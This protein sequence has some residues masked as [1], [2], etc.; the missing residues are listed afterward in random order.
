[1]VVFC[2]QSLPAS[3]N[4]SLKSSY[5][6]SAAILQHGSRLLPMTGNF[7][8][9]SGT[10]PWKTYTPKQHGAAR[11]FNY[12]EAS[13]GSEPECD[14]NMPSEDMNR[15]ANTTNRNNSDFFEPGDVAVQNEQDEIEEDAELPLFMC[16]ECGCEFIDDISLETHIF[17]HHQVEKIATSPGKQKSNLQCTKKTPKSIK[18]QD[19]K[20]NLNPKSN[21]S[22][23][24]C[25][26]TFS[27]QVNIM[28][29]MKTHINQVYKKREVSGKKHLS[30]KNDY[31]DD[32]YQSSGSSGMKRSRKQSQPR[33]VVSPTYDNQ[34]I[35]VTK[36]ASLRNRQGKGQG[37]G[38]G[39]LERSDI[40][41]QL[42]DKYMNKLLTRKGLNCNL[43]KKG[44]LFPYHTRNSLAM[45][46]MFNH[47]D[48]KKFQCEHC[49]LKFRHRYQVVLHASRKHVKN[50]QANQISVDA[51]KQTVPNNKLNNKELLCTVPATNIQNDTILT[52]NVPDNSNMCVDKLN[53]HSFLEQSIINT[54]N[55]VN[56]NMPITI[57]TFPPS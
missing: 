57:P 8:T 12:M 36:G 23:M 41:S 1:M 5:E 9:N 45:H 32:L 31:C 54:N 13:D 49:V 27:N 43:C 44:S 37:Q 35:Q 15:M 17:T 40:V 25:K 51:D 21:Y 53:I 20:E 10:K 48:M 29:H 33:K 14:S 50:N 30:K 4:P 34:E 52:T 55:S 56:N 3:V 19:S 26:S 11:L 7:L 39:Q 47:L 28:N 16:R 42:R 22:C 6:L 24:V 46:Y 38:H 2:S 18:S